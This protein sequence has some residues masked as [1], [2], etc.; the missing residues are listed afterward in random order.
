MIITRFKILIIIRCYYHDKIYKMIYNIFLIQLVLV[1]LL[2][3]LIILQLLYN[4]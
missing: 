1:L 4:F 3:T 2:I